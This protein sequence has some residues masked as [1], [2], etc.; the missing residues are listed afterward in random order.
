MRYHEISGKTLGVV[1][2]GAI[3][4]NVANAAYALGMKV[5]GYDPYI[6]LKSAWNLSSHI[7]KAATLDEIYEKCDIICLHVPLTDETKK[8]INADSIS[9][10]KDGVIVINLSRA[11]LVDDADMKNALESGK[12]AKYITDLSERRY[13]Q[14]E[15]LHKH[16]SSGRIDRGERG[17]LRVYG[18]S[19][20]YRLSGKRK[21]RQ[22]G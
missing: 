17:Q 5:L 1:G 22:F 19:R 9:K 18:G 14:D 6:S 12:A 21:H 3:G 2:L 13:N 20:A 10:M 11:D 4:V 7:A 15:K 16:S 8:F